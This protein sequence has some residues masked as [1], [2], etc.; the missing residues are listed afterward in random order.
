VPVLV[1]S[2]F[3]SQLTYFLVS[4]RVGKQIFLHQAPSRLP[5]CSSR[6]HF[7]PLFC[8]FIFF[9]PPPLP[10]AA[11]T[12]NDRRAQQEAERFGL[13][14]TSSLFGFLSLRVEQ[15]A[16]RMSLSCAGIKR[17][18]PLLLGALIIDECAPCTFSQFPPSS[19]LGHLFFPL[20]TG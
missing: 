16:L 13:V 15:T 8:G 12:S 2:P 11:K 19:L 1:F 7:S 14:R 3:L 18:R 20:S 5:D 10:P 17:L 9:A 6:L 4:S